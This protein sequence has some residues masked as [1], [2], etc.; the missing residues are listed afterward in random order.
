MPSPSPPLPFGA[1]RCTERPRVAWLRGRPEGCAVSF[2]RRNF[3][4]GAG[5]D[6]PQ[7]KALR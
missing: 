1:E 2:I 3:S 5:E 6:T 4:E 7:T